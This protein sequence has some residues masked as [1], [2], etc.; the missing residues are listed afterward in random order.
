MRREK[1]RTTRA[2][3]DRARGK[4]PNFTRVSEISDAVRY[5]GSNTETPPLAKDKDTNPS[6]EDMPKGHPGQMVSYV[7]KQRETLLAQSRRSIFRSLM[8]L[9]CS[10]ARL[11]ETR[12]RTYTRVFGHLRIFLRASVSEW[13]HTTGREK[14][15]RTASGRTTSPPLPTPG[16]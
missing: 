8:R 15:K 7:P 2:S 3:R 13:R 16:I 12:M 9:P 1:S 5:Y 6:T 4:N 11:L 10:L 14:K